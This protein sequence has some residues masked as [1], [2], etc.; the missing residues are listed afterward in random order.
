MEIANIWING[1]TEPIGFQLAP[2]II[3]WRIQDGLGEHQKKAT[4][5]VATDEQFDN[6]VYFNEGNLDSVGVNVQLELKP[7]TKYFIKVTVLA[8]NNQQ[9]EK[10]SYF[11]TGKLKET[12]TANW[13]G[14]RGTQ[15]HHPLFKKNFQIKKP[16]KDARLYICGLGLYEAQLNN[17][18]IGDEVLTPFL[19]D[20]D[21]FLQVQTYDV[22]KQ[23]QENNQLSVLLGNG[24][25]KGRF[26][27]DNK[28]NIFG[29]RFALLAE[30][31][32]S[33][34]DGSSEKILTDNSW[35]CS[36]SHVLTSG[37]YDGEHIDKM[38]PIKPLQVVLLDLGY[39]KLMDRISPKLRIQEE[40]PAKE[41][42][43]TSKKEVVLDFGQNFA[44]WLTFKDHFNKGH[45]VLFEF[46]EILQDGSFYNDNYKTATGG[47]SYVSDGKMDVIRPHFTYFGFRYVRVTGWDGIT[48]EDIKGLAIYSDLE[49]TGFIETGNQKINQLYSN[50]LWGIKSNFVDMPTDCPQRDERLGWTGDAQVF[51]PTASYYYDTRAFYHKF[52][53][54]LACEQKKLKGS[55]PEYLPA[56]GSGHGA[57]VWGDAATF[58]PYELLKK[59]GCIDEVAE[60]YQLMKDWVDKTGDDIEAVHGK[61][62]ALNDCHFELGDWLALDGVLPTSF[63]GGTDDVFIASVYYCE[64][65]R[66]VSEVAGLMNKLVEQE[67]YGM[68]A[69]NV[70]QTI[71][72][73]YFTQT[74]RLSVDTQAGYII[75]LKFGIYTDKEVVIKQLQTRL[76]K[77]LYRIKTGFVGTPLFCQTLAEN[78]LADLAYE[79]LLQEGFPGW[80]YAVDLGATTI[81]ERWN[82]VLP[83]GKMNPVGM[84]SLNHYSYGA[85]IEFLYKYSAGIQNKGYGFKEITLAPL[86]NSN[87]R[88]LDATYDSLFGKIISNWRILSNGEINCYFEV[89]FNTE[90]TICL[91][92]S[93]KD[94]FVVSSGKYEYTYLPLKNLVNPY[95]EHTR[96]SMIKNDPVVFDHLQELNPTLEQFFTRANDE[97][98]DYSLFELSN[99][100]YTGVSKE[101]VEQAKDYLA[102]IKS[103]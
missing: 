86:P 55:I 46:G 16:I 62:D 65:L 98:L 54:D 35:E 77:D 29:D 72:T 68:H 71:L 11:E 60:Y 9:V 6:L 95:D 67:Y 3:S 38:E 33:Y 12:W 34:G 31:V 18:K 103:I 24:W 39:D 42:I 76:K 32:I 87:L 44:G 74:G 20:Y 15:E 53:Y 10:V 52:L 70:K 90:A 82:S 96:I 73:E 59:Y 88:Y 47:F 27:L 84:N 89:P 14:Y 83:D 61:R 66:M 101:A 22:S 69:Q 81:W 37:I 13:I 64:S 56:L 19:N 75:A 36:S 91:P 79:I 25:Y 1:L 57:S 4:L 80:L 58:I 41:V 48:P 30:L 78:G 2:V 97:Q 21:T 7:R 26:G 50:T 49:R 40:L 94:P 45:K 85:V 99:L 17:E 93:D 102:K 92:Y 5:E 8:S 43:H 51:A 23:L 28:E 63:K 100:F